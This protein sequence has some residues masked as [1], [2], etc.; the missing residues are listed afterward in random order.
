MFLSYILILDKAS[1]KDH[2]IKTTFVLCL[3][4][5][6]QKCIFELLHKDLGIRNWLIVVLNRK[7]SI[8]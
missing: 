6:F 4:M 8:K 5:Y 1:K 7:N 3:S 2:L